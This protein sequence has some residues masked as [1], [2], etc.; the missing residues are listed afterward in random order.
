VALRNHP[1]RQERRR[2]TK[3]GHTILRTKMFQ[4][5]WVFELTRGNTQQKRLGF[6]KSRKGNQTQQ[7][8]TDSGSR[9]AWFT[10]FL[11]RKGGE[12]R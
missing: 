1:N 7:K 10:F 4:N 11:K 3:T 8:S 9:E 2:E 12:K 6:G 5:L